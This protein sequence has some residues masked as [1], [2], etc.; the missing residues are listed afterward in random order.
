MTPRTPSLVGGLK[1]PHLLR[2]TQLEERCLYFLFYNVSMW[3]ELQYRYLIT[4]R[5]NSPSLPQVCFIQSGFGYAG[6][7][8]YQFD[9]FASRLGPVQFHYTSLLKNPLFVF[10]SLCWIMKFRNCWWKKLFKLARNR[11]FLYAI[12]LFNYSFISFF[13]NFPD[14]VFF[15]MEPARTDTQKLERRDETFEKMMKFLPG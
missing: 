15:D 6:G 10:V 12:Y 4:I 9:S 13:L 1:C 8:A 2:L 14:A 5:D 7:P 11:I 3:C